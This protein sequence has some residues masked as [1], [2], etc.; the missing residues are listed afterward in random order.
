M[1]PQLLYS[2][3]I[4]HFG[5]HC[6]CLI[7]AIVAKLCGQLLI[8][9]DDIWCEIIHP[10]QFTSELAWSLFTSLLKFFR[11]D[12]SSLDNLSISFLIIH[13]RII[14][15]YHSSHHR[16]ISTSANSTAP[17]SIFL[18]N[19]RLCHEW[20]ILLFG[21]VAPYVPV[22][23]PSVTMQKRNRMLFTSG[24]KSRKFAPLNVGG[25]GRKHL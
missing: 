3:I 11:D 9:L 19:H 18:T 12:H 4:S 5:W 23:Y 7:A 1:P 20:L 14:C 16:A 10:C 15:P 17:P 22:A 13:L 8:I 25:E 2:S 24:Q 21:T 6:C